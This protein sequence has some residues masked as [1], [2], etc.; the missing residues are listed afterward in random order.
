MKREVKV[1]EGTSGVITLGDGDESPRTNVT[2]VPKEKSPVTAVGTLGVT[3][4]AIGGQ[5]M[6]G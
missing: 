3:D 5:R 4:G 6:D 2:T 1:A